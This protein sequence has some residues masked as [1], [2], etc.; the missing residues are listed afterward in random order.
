MSPGDTAAKP[1]SGSVLARLREIKQAH[2][3][4]NVF[5]APHPVLGQIG[6]QQV[7]A[8]ARSIVVTDVDRR[9]LIPL[10]TTTMTSYGTVQLR[11]DRRLGL[12]GP[13]GPFR[14]GVRGCP[15]LVAA[16]GGRRWPASVASR[17]R[18]IGPTDWCRLAGGAAVPAV[19]V[20]GCRACAGIG[21]KCGAAG[22]LAPT[23][24]FLTGPRCGGRACGGARVTRG[25]RADSSGTAGGDRRGR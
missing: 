20:I 6:A 3:P 14:P 2:D 10:F 7:M 8:P 16:T 12:T 19:I 25:D 1:F 18:D 21:G 4:H 22:C 13:P 23:I 11:R 17:D 9:G 15:G 24:G 5:R